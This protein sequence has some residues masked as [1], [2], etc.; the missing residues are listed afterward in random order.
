MG[1]SRRRGAEF[2]LMSRNVPPS[3]AVMN[4]IYG[5]GKMSHSHHTIKRGPA[6]F[7]PP[8]CLRLRDDGDMDG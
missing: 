3:A 1:P 6:A 8:T 4:G 5:A 2:G 7:R